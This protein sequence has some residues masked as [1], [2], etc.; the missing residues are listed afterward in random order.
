MSERSDLGD[1]DREDGSELGDREREREREEEE[2]DSDDEDDD[3][4]DD[5]NLRRRARAESERFRYSSDSER[6][7]DL[8]EDRNVLDGAAE[9]DF[10]KALEVRCDLSP[11]TSEVDEA[12]VLS[13]ALFTFSGEL[14]MG[15]E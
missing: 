12:S 11:T 2:L 10:E 14:C 1:T 7:S 13:V 9:E 5:E 3:A 4:E 6:E 8:D 15:C